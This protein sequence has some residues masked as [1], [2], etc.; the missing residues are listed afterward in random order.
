[1]RA[2]CL[3]LAVLFISPIQSTSQNLKAQ[4][5]KN[6]TVRLQQEKALKYHGALLRRPTPGY[7]YDRFYNAWLDTSSITE[8]ESFLKGQVENDGATN[9]RLLLAFFYAKQGEDVRALEEFRLA[10]EKDANNAETLYEK[11]VVEARTLDFDSALADLAKA[12]KS[13][14]KQETAIKIAQLRGRLLVR[15]RQD[16]EAIKI[17]NDL[18]EKNSSDEGLLE[19][20]IELQISEGLYDEANKLSDRLIKVTKDPFQKVVRSLRKG[21]IYVRAG[22]RDKALDVYGTALGKV[23]M[24][25]WLERKIL[26]QIEQLFRR[27]DDITSLENHLV[28]LIKKEKNRLSV[29]KA[30]SKVL[31]ELG[32][33]E[34]AIEAF[35]GILEVAPGDRKLREEFI[36]LLA[37]AQK[38]EQAI[39]QTESLIEQF[40][41]DAELQ[42]QLA[43]LHHANQQPDKA[44]A[45]IDSFLEVSNSTE[46]AH[47]RSA[48]MLEK[49]ENFD[50]A[51]EVYQACVKRFPELDS[52]KESYAAF[53]YKREKK[54]EAIAIWKKLAD[55]AD[56]VK[57]VRIA[58]IVSARQEHEVAY[59]ILR[60]RF[61]DFKLDS[62]FLGQLCNEAIATKKFAEATPW[63]LARIR[64]A[65]TA[66]DLDASLPQA[67]QVVAKA[68]ETGTTVE[69]LNSN[70]NRNTPQSCFLAELLER[71]S[72]SEAAAKLLD[73]TLSSLGTDNNR[74]NEIQMV[75]RQIVRMHS[76]RQDWD[77]A[78][79][80]AKQMVTL[81]GGRKSVNI[82]QLVELY[83]KARNLD[84]AITWLGEWKKVSPGS[85]LPWFSESQIYERKGEFENSINVLRRATQQFP[86]DAELFS[87]LGDRYTQNGQYADAE[88]IYWRQ[89]EESQ[90]LSDKLIWSDRLANLSDFSG[91]TD[92]LL[93]KFEERRRN[94]PR[95]I[96]PL[97]ALAQVHRVA[98]NYEERRQALVEATRLQKD[99]FPLLMEIARMEEAEGDWEEAIQT[100]EEASKLDTSTRAE[101]Q[102]ARILIQFGES[103]EGF[104]RLLTIAGGAKSNARD[105]E[106]IVDAIISTG[107]W[108]QAREFLIPQI[109]RFENDYRLQFQFGI[110][111][112][113]SGRL[114]EAKT[115]FIGLLGP[116]EDIVGLKKSTNPMNSYIQ[117]Q[118][119]LMADVM[120]PTA[121]EFMKFMY[122][123]SSVYEYRDN[124]YSYMPTG[125]GNGY[126]PETVD[127]CRTYSL[128]HLKGIS[129]EL[130]KDQQDALIDEVTSAGVDN[131]SLFLDLN[132]DPFQSD[133]VFLEKY[134]ADPSNDTLLALLVMQ[135]LSDDGARPEIGAEAYKRFRDK[136]PTLSFM[137]ALQAAVNDKQYDK[138]YGELLDTSLSETD[139]SANLNEFVVPAIAQVLAGRGTGAEGHKL[140]TKQVG[141]LNELLIKG[142]PHIKN[143]QG[144]DQ[145]MFSMIA[146]SLK[147]DEDPNKYIEFLDME[148]AR[149]QTAAKKPSSFPGFYSSQS[150]Q[151]FIG[152]PNFPPAKLVR[153]P[154]NIL[155]QIWINE[156]EF[157]MPSSGP[158][159]DP[160]SWNDKFKE[161]IEKAKDP[162]LKTLLKIKLVEN[163]SEAQSKPEAERWTNTRTFLKA[164]TLSQPPHPDAFYLA[165]TLAAHEERWDDAADYF[166]KMRNLPLSRNT[167][168]MIDGH[169]V[170]LAT[171]GSTDAVQKKGPVLKSAQAA[172]LRLRRIRLTPEQ[173]MH[174]V[175][176][177][178]TLGLNSEAKKM[179]AAQSA[180]GNF[181]SNIFGGGGNRRARV[182]AAPAERVRE[183][184]DTGKTEAATR[185]LVQEFRGHARSSMSINSFNDND[186]EVQELE[187][188]I[189]SY[190][191]KDQFLQQLDPGNSDASL[192]QLAF[193]FAHERFG[194]KDTARSI[195]QQ[196]L[197]K[198][199]RKDGVRLRLMLIELS[200]PASE[201]PDGEN[202]FTT[203]FEKFQKR[204]RSMVGS[205]LLQQI[206]YQNE[207]DADVWLR[208]GNQ[209]ADYLETLPSDTKL[210]LEFASS[211]LEPMNARFPVDNDQYEYLDS[212]FKK[213][214]TRIEDESE[215]KTKS[216][217]KLAEK[218][219]K[220]KEQRD[221]LFEKIARKLIKFPQLAETGFTA[222]LAAAEA[223][224][225]EI[226]EEFVQLAVKSIP[227]PSKNGGS[228]SPQQVF[229][230]SYGYGYS[231]NDNDEVKKRT[232]VDFLARHFGIN[233]RGNSELE[234][235]LASL[236]SSKREK[237]AEA[238]RDK[239]QLYVVAPSEFIAA[240]KKYVEKQAKSQRR[241]PTAKN[242][243]MEVVIDVWI[244]REQLVDIE[245]LVVEHV[246]E[247]KVS[248]ANYGQSA[249][250][251]NYLLEVTKKEGADRL[252][253]IL[254]KLRQHYLGTEEEQQALVEEVKKNR[255]PA[256][257]RRHLAY[258]Q[259]GALLSQL[260]NNMET[261]VIVIEEFHN[262]SMDEIASNM[263]YQ[264]ANMLEDLAVMPAEEARNLLKNT[265]FL[266]DVETFDPFLN[267]DSTSSPSIWIGGLARASIDLDMAEENS[268][269]KT[270]Q[271]KKNR[272]FG[273]E[274]FVIAFEDNF[275]TRGQDF[276][277]LL[278][279]KL[280]A[281][282]K[283][284][285]EKQKRLCQS[286]AI[287][288]SQGGRINYNPRAY[289]ASR[290]ISTA[291]K[292]MS[293]T[294][295][296]D[297]SANVEKLIAAKRPSDLDMDEYELQQWV[298]QV[299]QQMDATKPQPIID[300]IAKVAKWQPK[301]NRYSSGFSPNQLISTIF[302]EE[303]NYQT[304][305]LMLDVLAHEKT[306]EFGFPAQ[307]NYTVQRF[308]EMMVEEEKA[309]LR[310]SDTEQSDAKTFVL[311]IDSFHRTL[312]ETIGDRDATL[313]IPVY[314]EYLA[315]ADLELTTLEKLSQ[316]AKLESKSGKY[317][318]LAE[319]WSLAC[320]L[321]I[322]YVQ[323]QKDRTKW[324]EDN[325]ED[326][327]FPKPERNDSLTDVQSRLM[328]L[329][330]N[331][332]RSLAW[333]VQLGTFAL[334]HDPK[335]PVSSALECGQAMADAM[336]N[337]VYVESDQNLITMSSLLECQDDENFEK[338]ALAYGNAWKR[339]ALSPA[340]Q[341]GYSAVSTDLM[342]NAIRLFAILDQPSTV[343][344]I[345]RVQTDDLSNK[346]TIATL[347]ECGFPQHA[348]RGF[349]AWSQEPGSLLPTEY[350]ETPTYYTKKLHANLPETYKLFNDDSTRYLAEVFFA[351]LDD[352]KESG[353]AHSV[354]KSERLTI[355]AK[356]YA[357]YEFKSKSKRELTECLL[358]QAGEVPAN[359][360]KA[361]AES[362]GKI[363]IE[364][365]WDRNHNTDGSHQQNVVVSHLV[366]QI[367]Q[368]NFDPLL[369]FHD[370]VKA[371]KPATREWGFEQMV[372]SLGSQIAS[373]LSDKV[374]EVKPENLVKFAETLRKVGG[375]DA[376]I[377]GL[378][379]ASLIA[380]VLAGK[381]E[382]LVQL[383]ESAPKQDKEEEDYYYRRT[384]IDDVWQRIA[385]LLADNPVLNDSEKRVDMVVDIWKVGSAAKFDVGSGH[386]QTGVQESCS[387]CRDGKFGMEAIIEAK[388]LTRDELVKHGAR[389]AEVESVNGEIWRQIAKAQQKAKQ[390]EAAA[391]SFKKAYEGGTE[392]M[393]QAKSNRAVEYANALLELDRNEEA[394]E[395]LKD[396]SEEQLL[397][398]NISVYK[399]LREKLGLN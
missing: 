255:R 65:K 118:M 250:L 52:A 156:D 24:D 304:M 306:S 85:V 299:I 126:L 57:L 36:A 363:K 60:E 309:S 6:P 357:D 178:E 13:K 110:I 47:L 138:Q 167:R 5:S 22:K 27:E 336:T 370:D 315:G 367:R 12:A 384:D 102:I 131:A 217:I 380:H 290:K 78:A 358:S 28:Q 253:G 151:E 95:S 231:D 166:E 133:A 26:G 44:A 341:M 397:G 248:S 16:K 10:L 373:A 314:S 191:L 308:I 249:N 171:E 174:L 374:A 91:N 153:I 227:E 310:K 213:Q 350:Y 39:K 251:S 96:E 34:E 283:L 230:S 343:S 322:P 241:N 41:E 193:A 297:S 312:G 364:Q 180:A 159:M 195:Y 355:L 229:Y 202:P 301:N 313:L 116:Q 209:I 349:M 237:M 184:V 317:K 154:Q 295:N 260:Q 236:E 212:I 148:I 32:M 369:K 68:D 216:E 30:H 232:P 130:T 298:P 233:D 269:F 325:P 201:Q 302:S 48:R 89:Y 143:A 62:V 111:Q 263:T 352:T 238:I 123:S 181:F 265:A 243:A 323:I 21:D 134:D 235:I 164:L 80:A 173:R 383:Y 11:A 157:Y 117:N 3:F 56:R 135:M 155:G 113:E 176:V 353:L 103:R 92:K 394:K 200:T 119:N 271:K 86:K 83:S 254:A 1:M 398:D 108:D 257:S 337:K 64:L 169:L 214:S 142:Y 77:A 340:Y 186:Y 2:I 280:D 274:I 307:A 149:S 334:Q 361:L 144:M 23:G 40:P 210:D 327:P 15:N 75:S 234:S 378:S 226:G 221:E 239:H 189:T 240:S 270:M 278:D 115:I 139:I 63:V 185:L 67:I 392:E 256:R 165:G 321:T 190:G 389:F 368:G 93:E 179:E 288:M 303:T 127:M 168:E 66:G 264:F 328:E 331:T 175:G 140:S 147:K 215:K 386:F 296:G 69:A 211:F 319:S 132:I 388:L 351:S 183:L 182:A 346:S 38:T 46:I 360:E 120:P 17:W 87:R 112:E 74:A 365:L 377:R 267:P 348:R 7:L 31:F 104:S 326:S 158:E 101:E 160:S 332:D 225:D 281:V 73:Q 25:S 199:A 43:N 300:V 97:L 79:E 289:P 324:A 19:D 109:G 338:V 399:G 45:A 55:Q 81:P 318:K 84:A 396:I 258:Q 177:F 4:D 100:L 262:L 163:D 129:E 286:L 58:R 354:S 222:L 275:T 261:A 277:K 82:R 204:N 387:G 136:Y 106:A 385:K 72:D 293:E 29:R 146:N 376:V 359:I 59:E 152:L 282:K 8:L 99:S 252:R 50:K 284:P 105:V 381:T 18:V 198:D 124:T 128:A 391:E 208:L 393:E 291:S 194:E 279:T 187:S 35:R 141:Q 294:L 172:A 228:M 372:E 342:N 192:T 330:N 244:D 71:Q 259:Y 121:M 273:E 292:F 70:S 382:D 218:R 395:L 242:A 339:K 266:D 276:L 335:L 114:E 161:S 170:A 305:G 329:V 206:V 375:P 219:N 207:S 33:V 90:K 223:R 98:D 379:E 150:Q 220:L 137:G 37:R 54:P 246:T 224:G 49:F 345:I 371:A 333:R 61:H 390:A 107:D 311:A 285:K 287:L 197:A 88:R 320:D 356:K 14:P 347:V 362:A 162:I 366:L 94:N 247:E 51:L 268:F 316:W 122:T 203:H 344:Q 53:L 196:A 245:S 125:F 145:W 20:I 272:T 205:L 76:S 9:D 42:I 188:K